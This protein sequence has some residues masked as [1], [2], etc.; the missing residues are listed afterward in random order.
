MTLADDLAAYLSRLW[1]AP[2]DVERLDRIPG[3]ASR[4]TYRFDAVI[5][6]ARRPLILRRDP[7]GSLI[8]T[9]R[10]TEYLAYASFHPLGA[11]VPEPIALETDPGPLGRPFFLMSRI[12]GG[13]AAS[14]FALAPYKGFEADIGKAFFS[15]LGG[16]T[17]PDPAD[18]PVAAVC[19]ATSVTSAWSDQLA[20]WE[21]ELNQDE[22][23]PSPIIR[24]A[25]RRLRRRP[26]PPAQKLCVVHG[27]Y[28]SGNF[29]HD[30]QGRILAILDWEMAHL[31]DPL[32]DLAWALDP[33]WRHEDPDRVA[34]MV[35]KAEALRLWET[36][37][38]L[39]ADPEA[40]AWWELFAS[41]K[42]L[43]IWISAARAF[44]D[45]G[46][47]DPVLGF[48]GLYCARRHEEIIANTLER[49]SE[50]HA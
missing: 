20:H 10:R 42:G 35:P 32:E 15:I 38:G 12:D 17:R 19:P 14:P 50:T 39:R 6:G 45:G 11:P 36:A 31:G 25:I 26:P 29:L 48:T 5:G 30:G 46:G 22:L 47:L 2:C 24:A 3:G 33:L 34:G 18:L 7:P 44:R 1:S 27:D 23:H 43:V 13:G 41:V 21:A 49:L 37:S 40:L 28:R 8:D 9:D 16:L 4:E